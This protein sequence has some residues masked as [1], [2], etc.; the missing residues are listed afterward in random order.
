MLLLLLVAGTVTFVGVRQLV[1]QFSTT[2]Q[3]LEED[4]TIIL[5]LRTDLISNAL[6]AHKLLAGL[7]ESRQ[8]FQRQ[9]NNIS[10]EFGHALRTFPASYGTDKLIAKADA[11]WQSA[12]TKAGL[13]GA[14]VG[15]YKGTHNGRQV[16]FETNSDGALAILAGLEK[17]SLNA[18]RTGLAKGTDLER[19]LMVALAGL[20]G[21]ALVATVYFRRRMTRDLVRPVADM[22]QGVM[23]LEAGDFGYRIA[24][25]RRDELGE[26]ADAFNGMAGALH[27][28][29]L[30]LTRQATHDSLTGLPNRTSLT[31]RLAASFGAA[32]DR[33][34]Q[35]EGVLFIDVDDFKDVN[36]SLGHQGGDAL[37]IE[38]AA[39]LND[40][41]RPSDLVARL[42]G[43]EFAI[44]VTEDDGGSTSVDVAERI[45]DAVHRP[46]TVAEESLVVSVSIG[47]AQRRPE[48]KDAAELLRR[49]DFAMYMAKGGGKGRYQLFD[50]KM[51]DTMVGRSALKSELAH[52]VTS[53]QLRLEYQPVAD[54]RTGEILG[55]EALVRWQHPTLGLL[56]PSEF[57][58]LAEE[59]GDIEAIGCWVLDA[60]THQVA[61]WRATMAQCSSLWVAVNLSLY[62]LLNP[63]SLA[64]LQQILSDPDVQA[65]NVVLEVTET[66]LAS[67]V[68][69]GVAKLKTLKTLGVRL[70]IDDFGTGFSSLSTLANLPID[71]L[72]IDR[73]FVSG[74]VSGS[75]SVPMLEGILGL[76]HKLGLVVI[77][78]GIEKPDQL[79]LLRDLGCFTGQGYLLARPA[80]PAAV[81]A[82]LRAG[83]IVSVPVSV[84]TG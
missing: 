16:E 73:A 20:F 24:V 33:R 77:A 49:A 55:L 15:T 69:G 66:A 54:L 45:L 57:I 26:L 38:L 34:A 30:A 35:H 79:E 84:P 28:S 1:G 23:S 67:D 48:I 60:A 36:D 65:D 31:Q 43:D 72:K 62:Q 7:P 29:H 63:C 50:A 12:L 37:L 46:F 10:R 56:P 14:E 64:A 47:V 52:A 59:T 82:L 71:I 75:P 39:R 61:S 25:A 13:W 42:G 81:E 8:T 11:S 53:G 80:P 68:D 83:R 19:V 41:V 58:A 27:D 18:V 74:H 21:L 78:E 17:P 5:T 76:A 6:T 9:E 4:S 44:V 40:C 22:H 2:G 70:A 32:A 51:H 3:Q